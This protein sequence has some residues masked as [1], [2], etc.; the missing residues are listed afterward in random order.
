M[1]LFDRGAGIGVVVKLSANKRRSGR[2]KKKERKESGAELQDAALEQKVSEQEVE[3]PVEV[4][5]DKEE[6]EKSES[7]LKSSE[8]KLILP[9]QFEEAKQ[10]TVVAQPEPR[11]Q[12]KQV[13]IEPEAGQ[14]SGGKRVAD[15]REGM[16]EGFTKMNDSVFSLDGVKKAAAWYIET[17]EKLAKQALELQEKAT[18]WAKDTPFAPLF[19]AQHSMA[20]KLVERSANAARTLWQ[21]H[22]TQ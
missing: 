13:D 7:E 22:P 10:H 21:I 16:F 18:G 9:A 20:R 8:P 12:S 2:A 19:E 3:G 1:R 15:N 11:K 5:T 14:K 17:S 4:E 6:K